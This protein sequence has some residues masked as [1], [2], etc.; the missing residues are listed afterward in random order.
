MSMA[1]CRFYCPCLGLPALNAERPCHWE[2]Q[3][4]VH[5][6]Q[7]TTTSDGTI[8]QILILRRIFEALPAYWPRPE[9]DCVVGKTGARALSVPILTNLGGL[10]L[11]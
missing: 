7:L 5:G 4:E 9:I 2:A 8:A 3:S 11:L 1:D 10:D 6:L